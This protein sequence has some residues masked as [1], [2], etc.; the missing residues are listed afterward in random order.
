MYYA[1]KQRNVQLGDQHVCDL[2]PSHMIM[3]QIFG[4]VFFATAKRSVIVKA[5]L[6]KPLEQ[7]S[8]HQP[9]LSTIT[10]PLLDSGTP[11]PFKKS[12]DGIT[13]DKD[14]QDT[15]SISRSFHNN[16][17]KVL[18]AR[19]QSDTKCGRFVCV[20][21]YSGLRREALIFTL[22]AYENSP[23]LLLGH[24]HQREPRFHYQNTQ[25]LTTKTKR[26]DKTVKLVNTQ[27]PQLRQ[28]H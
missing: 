22:G 19:V 14:K 16:L 8:I 4:V 23:H 27:L 24:K 2:P 6:S 10:S 9:T 21:F 25:Q 17:T 1:M 12:V 13:P 5:L 15:P 3:L 7:N 18:R 20:M 26:N 28:K 11:L